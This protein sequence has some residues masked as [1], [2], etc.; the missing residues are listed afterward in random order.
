MKLVE[1]TVENWEKVLCLTT[2]EAG[3]QTLDEEFVASNAFSMVQAQFEPGWITRAL[4]EDGVPVGFAMYGF[5]RD[6]GFYELCRLMI[7]RRYQGRG[8]GIRAVRLI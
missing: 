6:E 1:I 2:N 5:N 3:M 4:E 7:D 8:F